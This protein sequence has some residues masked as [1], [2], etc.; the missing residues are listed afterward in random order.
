LAGDARYLVQ[1]GL[2]MLRQTSRPGLRAI[3]K[4]AEICSAGTT[5]EHVGFV[6]APRLNAM[7][8]LADA[9]LEVEY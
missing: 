7:G 2:E 6:I 9:A 5:E 3:Y 1:Q 8:R 4:A